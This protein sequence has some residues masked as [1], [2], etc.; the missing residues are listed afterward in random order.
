MAGYHWLKAVTADKVEVDIYAPFAVS[1]V[2]RMFIPFVVQRSFLRTANFRWSA[3]GSKTF[4]CMRIANQVFDNEFWLMTG[5][6]AVVAYARSGKPRG[7]READRY[8]QE[9]QEFIDKSLDD[10]GIEDLFRFADI[11]GRTRVVPFL[12]LVLNQS[13]VTENRNVRT[14]LPDYTKKGIEGRRR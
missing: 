14:A 13:I 10:P 1:G 4:G 6:S 11:E 9:V 3:D 2:R 5:R 8:R 12:P 7:F